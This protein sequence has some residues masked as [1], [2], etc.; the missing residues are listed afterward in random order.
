MDVL[1]IVGAALAGVGAVLVAIGALALR[2]GRRFDR[3]ARRAP[4][5]VV[6]V[7]GSGA[8]HLVGYPVLRFSLPD[9]RE[10]EARARST[11]T[12]DAL[13]EGQDVTVLYDPADPTRARLDTR[14]ASAGQALLGAGFM[15]IGAVLVLLGVA[16]IVAGIA[17][18][19]ALPV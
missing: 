5:R 9:G 8:G 14:T 2:A 11:T 4:G 18:R 15:G 10:I 3:V 6:G 16:A 7:A 17:L 13:R 12:L 1:V 19:D